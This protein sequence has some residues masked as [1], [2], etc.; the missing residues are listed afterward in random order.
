MTLSIAMNPTPKTVNEFRPNYYNGDI[1]A[2]VAA[3]AARLSKFEKLLTLK[4]DSANV[5]AAIML[6]EENVL[7]KGDDVAIVGNVSFLDWQRDL[8]GAATNVINDAS[9]TRIRG[10]VIQTG[11]IMGFSGNAWMDLDATNA[12]FIHTRL[13]SN[14]NFGVDIEDSGNFFFGDFTQAGPFVGITG[15]V[16]KV[17]GGALSVGKIQNTNGN[18]WIDLEA[19]VSEFIH[20]RNPT[21]PSYGVSLYEYGGFLMGDQNRAGPYMELNGTALTLGNINLNLTGNDINGGQIIGSSGTINLAA[22]GGSQ[23][24]YTNTPG[25]SILA[26]GQVTLGNSGGNHINYDGTNLNI[27]GGKLTGGGY[28]HV[29]GQTP[30]SV[31]INGT[32]YTSSVLGDTNTSN[33]GVIGNNTSTWGYGV[34]GV[35]LASGGV[36][37]VGFSSNGTGVEG[38]SSIGDGVVGLSTSFNAMLGIS[39][40]GKGMLGSSQTNTGAEGDSTSGIGVRGF[41]SSGH[42]IDGQSSSNY[43]GYFTGGLGVYCVGN[44]HATGTLSAGITD[45]SAPVLMR[46]NGPTGAIT[47]HRLWFSTSDGTVHID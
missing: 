45:L 38:I 26:N 46:A 29:T 23:F 28:T 8:T 18:S 14:T 22:T 35:A 40:S 10:G 39:T 47:S 6:S 32:S 13:A 16:L 21:Y 15:G 11:K 43:S 3:L 2:L 44:M 20:T 37:V 41:S 36:G 9:L 19:N 30:T 5:R 1:P 24:I 25:V 17:H 33:A 31:L 27:V 12:D 34:A 7:I 42:G 4:V